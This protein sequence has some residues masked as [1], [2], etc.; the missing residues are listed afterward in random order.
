[1]TDKRLL[2]CDDEADFAEFVRAVAE[3]MGYEVEVVTRSMRF[4][5]AYERFDPTVVLLD[6]VMPEMD[7]TEIIRWLSG[8]GASA[9]RIIIASGFTPKYAE[10][11]RL[12]AQANGLL[13]VSTL[14]KPIG[15]EALRGALV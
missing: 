3:P 5:D 1:M 13:R 2:V 4:T 15:V 11:A 6:M 14:A 10:M 8:R 12:I 7:G 9:A